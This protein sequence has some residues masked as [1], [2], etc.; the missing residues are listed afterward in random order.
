MGKFNRKFVKT[1]HHKFVKCRLSIVVF[2]FMYN[3][4]FSNMEH[5]MISL[6][7]ELPV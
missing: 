2:G 7:A 5:C 1:V 6:T 3:G 4:I